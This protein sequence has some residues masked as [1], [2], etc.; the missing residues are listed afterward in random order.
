MEDLKIESLAGTRE[1][2]RI[3]KLTGPFTL[4]TFFDFQSII[5]EGQSRMTIIDLSGVPYMDSAAL[6]SIL[7]FHVS[8]QREGRQYALVGV[9]DRL[10]T[11]F[12][13]AGVDGMVTFANS[14]DEAEAMARAAS[15][16][17]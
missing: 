10:M 3:L 17:A 6:G 15:A 16:S 14:V 13:V 12:R 11:I 8:C 9:S 2:I 5:R 7:G 1:G 4:T